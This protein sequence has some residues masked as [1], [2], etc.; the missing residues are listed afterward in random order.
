MILGY[1]SYVVSVKLSRT[2][3]FLTRFFRFHSFQVT[4]SFL[5]QRH[6]EAEFWTTYQQRNPNW[7]IEALLSKWGLIAEEINVDDLKFIEGDG[8]AEG[9]K[10]VYMVKMKLNPSVLGYDQ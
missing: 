3:D 1:G 10:S 8:P 6:P 7:S 4:V 9:M 5:L 2:I